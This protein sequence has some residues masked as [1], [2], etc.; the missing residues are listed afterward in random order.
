ML[1]LTCI[2]GKHDLVE[3]YSGHGVC[4]NEYDVVRWCRVCGSIVVDVDMD[5]KTMKPG[6]TMILKSPQISKDFSA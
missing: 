3:I 1:L 4:P 2:S 5:N 6:G